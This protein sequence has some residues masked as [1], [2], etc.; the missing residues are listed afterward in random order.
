MYDVL[1][2]I[3]YLTF[4]CFRRQVP[5]ISFNLANANYTEIHTEIGNHVQCSQYNTFSHFR[6]GVLFVPWARS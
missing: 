3:H 2:I 5:R 6:V 1:N 4:R